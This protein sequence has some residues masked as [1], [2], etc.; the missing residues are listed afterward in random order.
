MQHLIQAAFRLCLQ[1]LHKTKAFAGGC[2]VC[3]IL[4]KGMRTLAHN[5]FEIV[6]L[7]EPVAHVPPVNAHLECPS[8]RGKRS[9]S[10]GL[11]S[12]KQGCSSPSSASRR[13]ATLRVSYRTVLTSSV[14]SSG[15]KSLRASRLMP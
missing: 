6:L 3:F 8:G 7:R 1:R 9:H 13:W 12:I 4:S 2:L 15:R 10:P 5:D 14:T 11:P